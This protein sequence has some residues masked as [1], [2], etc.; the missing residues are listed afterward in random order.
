[1]LG[2][3]LRDL[4]RGKGGDL[5]E[6]LLAGISFLAVRGLRMIPTSSSEPTWHT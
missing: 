2:V 3:D 5:D 1:V 6:W 4:A